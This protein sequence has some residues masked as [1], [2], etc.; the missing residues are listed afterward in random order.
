[1]SETGLVVGDFTVNAVGSNH[2]LNERLETWKV[3]MT[4]L[5]EVD[6]KSIEI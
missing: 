5:D 6:E 3:E 4:G 2:H 1:M